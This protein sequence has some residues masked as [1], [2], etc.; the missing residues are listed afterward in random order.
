[1]QPLSTKRVFIINDND[2]DLFYTSPFQS[3]QGYF[4]AVVRKI[5]LT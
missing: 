4:V 5:S 3:N 2:D 1:M